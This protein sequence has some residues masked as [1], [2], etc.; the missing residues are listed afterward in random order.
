MLPDRVNVLADIGERAEDIDV[1][2][3]EEALQRAEER[4]KRIK[5]EEGYEDA[6]K[7]YSRRPACRRRRDAA[8][9][10]ADPPTTDR[11]ADQ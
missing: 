8:P 3:A 1:E 2:R 7:A 5:D 10:A 6:H 11:R 9:D 4:M